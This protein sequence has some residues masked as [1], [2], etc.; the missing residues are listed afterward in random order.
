MVAGLLCAGMRVPDLS[1]PHRP[2]PM[3]RLVLK[4]QVTTAPSHIKQQHHDVFVTLPQV[5][6][7]AVPVLQRAIT[8]VAPPR[9]IFL[10]SA[11]YSGR[12]P[13]AA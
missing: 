8:R 3:H 4:A 11:P 6:E 2:K 5:L 12:S 13:P 1:R 10:S 7:P 9:Y